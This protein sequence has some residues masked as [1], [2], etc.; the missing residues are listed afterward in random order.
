[1][2]NFLSTLGAVGRQKKYVVGVL[3]PLFLSSCAAFERHEERA[4][5][6]SNSLEESFLTQKSPAGDD[7]VVP[8]LVENS[9]VGAESSIFQRVKPLPAGDSSGLEYAEFS[10]SLSGEPSLQA[11]TESMPTIEF[12]HYALGELLD[13]EYV[14]DPSAAAVQTPVTLSSGGLQSP[15]RFY[16]TV[17]R[18]LG[19][20]DLLVEVED[21]IHY[22]YKNDPNQSGTNVRVNIGRDS[23]RVPNVGGEILQVV[24]LKYGTNLSLERTMRELLNVK[25]TLDVNQNALF[26]RGER[27]EIIKALKFVGMFD[28]PANRGRHIGV[29]KQTYLSSDEFVKKIASLMK[30]EGIP[31]GSTGGPSE[32]VVIV[33][34]PNIGSSAVFANSSEMLTRVRYWSSIIDQP[35]AGAASQY[36]VFHPR[37]ARADEIGASLAQLI[38]GQSTATISGGGTQTAMAGQRTGQAPSAARSQG[39]STDSMRMVV[40]E[41]SNSLVFYSSGMEYQGLLPLLNQ[42]DVLPKQVLL[43][44]VIAEV[45]LQDEFKFGFEWALQ[46]SEVSLST[47]GAFGANQI[48]GTA[49]AIAGSDGDLVSQVL[50]TS[51]LVNVLSNPTMLVRDGATANINVGSDI[52][53]VG[54]TTFDPINGQRQTTASTYRK[55][56]VDVTVTP[57]INAEGVVLMEVDKSISNAV[58]DSSGAGGNPDIFER[59]IRTEVVAASGQT[60]LLGGLISEDISSSGAGTPGLSEVPLLGWLFKSEGDSGSRTELVM[61]ITARIIDDLNEW[62]DLEGRFNDGLRYLDLSSE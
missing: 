14:I 2:K 58:P 4:S 37:F 46:N 20:N 8:S 43:D 6:S 10:K 47:L 31:V 18:V 23:T 62:E 59:A 61:L 29:L 30:A 12:V 42:L 49:L 3:L 44:I 16:Q 36:F 53:V 32:S 28:A 15:R 24:P 22:L 54:S 9:T 34:L 25:V 40:V 11:K 51:R 38:G 13:I 60:L 7:A 56:G 39:F 57:T 55:T 19:Q 41:G 5:S 50:R 17:L 45:T 27:K 52:S 33:P 1:M 48:G 26:L 21:S 35:A